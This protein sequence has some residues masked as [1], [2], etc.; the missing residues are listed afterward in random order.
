MIRNAIL[1]LLQIKARQSGLIR[2]YVKILT[3]LEKS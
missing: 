1:V 2:V 3:N